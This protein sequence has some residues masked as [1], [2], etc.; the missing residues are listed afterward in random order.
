MMKGSIYVTEY[1]I[2][3]MEKGDIITKKTGIKMVKILDYQDE[4]FR[5]MF[6]KISELYEKVYVISNCTGGEILSSIYWNDSVNDNIYLKSSMKV[7]IELSNQ[8]YKLIDKAH[9]LLHELIRFTTDDYKTSDS[10]IDNKLEN[11]IKPSKNDEKYNIKL[12]GFE[13]DE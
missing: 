2:K 13:D 12:I 5:K 9:A 6:N 3:G 11:L 8:Y 1:K 10:E 4:Q 7:G